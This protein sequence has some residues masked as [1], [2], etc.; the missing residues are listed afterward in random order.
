[1]LPGGIGAGG[2]SYSYESSATARQDLTLSQT[3]GGTA[4]VTFGASEK[5]RYAQYAALSFVAVVG[6]LVYAKRKKG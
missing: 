1:M 5:S 2:G 6:L 4:G 3:L